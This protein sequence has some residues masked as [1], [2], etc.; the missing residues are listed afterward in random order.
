MAESERYGEQNYMLH[1]SAIVLGEIKKRFPLKKG[2]LNNMFTFTQI[3][4]FE[5]N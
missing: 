4:S 1:T 3:A 2:F 5:W